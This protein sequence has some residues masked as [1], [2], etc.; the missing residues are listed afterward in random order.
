MNEL[1]ELEKLKI[2]ASFNVH[3]EKEGKKADSTWI[4]TCE[5]A[6]AQEKL[7]EIK[8]ILSSFGKSALPII[9]TLCFLRFSSSP[10]H[11]PPKLEINQQKVINE[12]GQIL[13]RVYHLY[14]RPLPNELQM[15]IA[16]E[17]MMQEYLSYLQRSCEIVVLRESDQTVWLF[18]PDD[19]VPDWKS[20]WKSFVKWR[21]DMEYLVKTFVLLVNS[22]R[23]ANRGLSSV[24]EIP[25]ITN[26][27]RWLIAGFYYAT[28][29]QTPNLYKEQL[30]EL[31]K[32]IKN[33]KDLKV[34][35]L[36]NSSYYNRNASTQVIE[37]MGKG[38]KL[39]ER[40]KQLIQMKESE[41]HKLDTLLKDQPH[42]SFSR[43]AGDR[44]NNFCYSCGC[45]LNETEPKLTA[46]KFIFS[47]PS[48][49]SQSNSSEGQPNICYDCAVIGF[50]SPVKLVDE[51]FIATFQKENES[52]RYRVENYIRQYTLAELNLIAGQRIVLPCPYNEHIPQKG[53][54]N[55]IMGTVQ[56]ALYKLATLF[57]IE[58]FETFD[59][60][61]SFGGTG[62]DCEVKLPKRHLVTLKLLLQRFGNP[63]A[64]TFEKGR[65]KLNDAVADAIRYIQADQV[66]FAEYVLAKEYS[67]KAGKQEYL[68]DDLHQKFTEL[69]R[70][71]VKP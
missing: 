63:S 26:A 1:G 43:T 21:F 23:L 64:I 20:Y 59:V 27:Q 8:I 30:N 40:I 56:Y 51:G 48:Q 46:N 47:S 31:E 19:Q 15:R 38:K 65:K 28:L 34:L 37:K 12:K 18:V 50:A 14:K 61:V 66:T 4:Q 9:R 13:G 7:D 10:Q 60:L 17:N 49:R 16:Y 71:E 57:P 53:S 67:E 3:C 25:I 35:L 5:W 52:D 32:D 22:V 42:F 24:P 39:V 33:K 29:R 41:F 36:I 69:L 2:L 55:K 62:G 54:L 6:I 70:E 44:A 58:V 45:G 11:G 68:A